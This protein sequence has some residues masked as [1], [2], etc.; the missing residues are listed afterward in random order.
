MD[1]VRPFWLKRI[2]QGW[3]HCPIVWLSGVRRVGKTT[4]AKSIEGAAYINCDLPRNREQL[5]QIEFFFE[6]L[7]EPIVIFD[8]IHQLENPSEVLKIGAD[9][10]PDKRILATGSSTLAATSKFSDSLTGRKRTVHLSPVISTELEAFERPLLNDRLLRGGMPQMLINATEDPEFYSEWLDS[11][12]A[13]DIQELF[14]VSK[15]YEFL[16]LCEILM[17]QNGGL[18]EITSLAKHSGLTRPTVSNYLNILEASHF[19]HILRPFH[20]GGRRE[21]LSQP[22][23]Y[24]FDTGFVAY[25]RGWN[26]LRPT[27]C[28]SLFENL[29]LDVLQAYFPE[30][31]LQFW[32]DKQN[33]EIDFVLPGGRNR[34]DAIECKWSLRTKTTRNFEAFRNNY[35]DGYNYMVTAEKITIRKEL[36]GD[37]TVFLCHIDDLPELIHQNRRKS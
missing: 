6:N 30:Q 21:I 36:L 7:K 13:R 5:K 31:K 12:Y 34:Y 16:K 28:G 9:E 3:S 2:E 20:A 8:E 17:R 18:A 27:D 19:I 33:R 11:F 32:K 23:I 4:L 1:V 26:E 35:P 29:V 25:Y 37:L 14:R 10:F 22:K 24:A 15:R